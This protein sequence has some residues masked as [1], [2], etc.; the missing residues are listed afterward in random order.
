MQNLRNILLLC[1]TL[2][3]LSGCRAGLMLRKADKQ[4]ANGEYFA[5]A[6]QY[7]KAY[8]RLNTSEKAK[9]GHAAFFRAE[10]F[11]LLNQPVKAESEYKKAQRLLYPND[12][13]YLRLA[14]TLH[15][16]AKY[17]E[18]TTFYEKYLSRFPEDTLALNGLYACHQIDKWKKARSRY[19]VKKST[20]FNSRKGDFSPVYNPDN[21]MTLFLTSSNKT[22][23]DKKGSKI[24]GLPDNDF[25]V[26]KLDAE[27]KW[28]KPTWLESTLNS[29]F[30][31]GAPCF[32]A[33]GK[34]I[35][36]TR[37]VTRADSIE[38]FSKAELFK[39]VRTGATW[40]EPEK[41]SVYRDS[42]CI[43]AH[44]A[45]S[46]DG[47]YLYFVSD[48]K[49][50]YGGKDIWRVEIQGD[51]Y[52]QPENLGPKINTGG[53]E[54]FPSFRSNGD[55]YFSS[56]GLPGFGGLDIF[57]ATQTKDGEWDVENL[58]Q[59]INSNGDDFGITFKGKD[60][61]GFFSSNRKEARGWDKI[62]S[63]EQPSPY[64]DVQGTV[65]DRYGEIVAD[66]TIR[67]VNDKGLNTKVRTG[68]NGQYTLKVDKDA[69]YVLLA[70][71]RSY[72][73]SSGRL[74]TL[75]MEKDTTYIQNFTL[76][77]LHKAVRIDNV[78]FAFDKWELL[79][80][81]YPALNELVKIMLD[82]PHIVVEI[83][84]H[85]DR[86]GTDEYND[87][88]SEKR[89]EAVVEYLIKQG[90]E[91]D[92]LDAKGYGKREPAMVDSYMHDKFLFLPEGTNLSEG[93]INTLNQEQQTIVDQINRRCEFKV[94][95][96]TYK[97]F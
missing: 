81:S 28:S 86:V 49:G 6:S 59:Q 7:S 54:L 23:K 58:M 37:C 38:T 73:N 17:T 79:P 51:S 63:F 52:G 60:D 84:A 22:E 19:A 9:R 14:Q 88:L 75:N 89:A 56:D 91:K 27:G 66:A 18:A 32:S 3:L 10:C 80:E 24:T 35:Y 67:V 4:Y 71:C 70:T 90:I 97:L 94:L 74:Y 82:N 15:K 61:S 36:F 68:K 64:A 57:K 39:S 21:Y 92:R 76:T 13:L 2:T 12:T 55:L 41:F 43:Y 77:P 31:E 96:T 5:A 93:Y 42:T 50:G 47:K 69:D 33:D 83:G 20:L 78:L 87:Y 34:T 72:L 65:T 45:A 53:D 62:Y 16:N 95:K 44:P 1:L 25:W 29:E 85:T 26:S 11:R 40:S 8:R 46:P 48:L 30:D